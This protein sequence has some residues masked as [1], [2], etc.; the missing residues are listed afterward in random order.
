VYKNYTPPKNN[1]LITAVRMAS[2]FT[3]GYFALVPQA[4]SAAMQYQQVKKLAV[5]QNESKITLGLEP[6]KDLSPDAAKLVIQNMAAKEFGHALGLKGAS[7]KEGDLLY[8][9]LRSDVAQLPSSRDLAT[10]REIYNRP[11]NI[12]LN[13]H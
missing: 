11:P 13:V 5:I 8:P 3:P 9:Q 1:P 4:A 6:V 12:L 7:P 10:L 2:M